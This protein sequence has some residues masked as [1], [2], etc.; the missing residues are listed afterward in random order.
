MG[1]NLGSFQISGIFRI[2]FVDLVGVLRPQEGFCF[3]GES[4]SKMPK[5]GT[6]VQL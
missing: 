4:R 5:P 6:S 1:L 2:V 3:P